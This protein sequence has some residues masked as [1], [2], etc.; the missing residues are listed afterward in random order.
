MIVGGDW[1]D[2]PGSLAHAA[3]TEHPLGLAS[4]YAAL[5]GAEPA[6]TSWKVRAAGEVKRTIDYVWFERSTLRPVAT[7]GIPDDGAVGAARLP[8]WQ[9]P[10]DHLA[11]VV[12]FAPAG[13]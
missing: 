1:N 5:D 7:L 4:A 3:V 9:Y 12:R 2:V 8:S 6:W 11:L 13:D 10:S